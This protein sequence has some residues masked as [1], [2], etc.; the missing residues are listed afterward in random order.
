VWFLFFE[1]GRIVLN[2]V[3]HAQSP[4]IGGVFNT[5]EGEEHCLEALAFVKEQGLTA[6]CEEQL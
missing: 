3:P 2:G 5:V 1:T 6:W 4:Q